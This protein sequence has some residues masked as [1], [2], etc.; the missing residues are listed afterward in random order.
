M[1]FFWQTTAVFHPQASGGINRPTT[2]KPPPPRPAVSGP[3]YA[4]V[5]RQ[6]V[7]C[8]RCSTFITGYRL[9]HGATALEQAIA[10][11]QEGWLSLA[12][13]KPTRLLLTQAY[14]VRVEPDSILFEMCCDECQ[15]RF[16]YREEVEGVPVTFFGVDLK[17]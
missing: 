16:S 13:D 7:A 1:T 8:G 3:T 9:L 6:F 11:Q 12:W 17:V 5:L 4:T 10:Q 15:R 2:K 14:D